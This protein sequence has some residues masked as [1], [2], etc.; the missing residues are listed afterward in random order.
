MGWGAERLRHLFKVT[1]L[2]Q[3]SGRMGFQL[4]VSDLEAQGR[5]LLSQ[6]CEAHC[7]IGSVLGYGI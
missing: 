4:S 7:V 6:H 3:V 5:D 2:I 1:Q